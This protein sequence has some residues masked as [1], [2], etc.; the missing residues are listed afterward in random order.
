MGETAIRATADVLYE[1]NVAKDGVEIC[2]ET[3]TNL[4]KTTVS[5]PV[6]SMPANSD[7]ILHRR[8]CQQAAVREHGNY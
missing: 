2:C 5:L 1:G 6:A 7:M 3:A 4:L 8:Y